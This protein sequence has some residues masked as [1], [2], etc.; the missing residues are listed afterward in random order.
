MSRKKQSADKEKTTRDT[1]FGEVETVE[2]Y[3]PSWYEG[4]GGLEKKGTLRELLTPM[5][6]FEDSA[7]FAEILGS[8]TAL[9]KAPGVEDGPHAPEGGV[10]M[11]SFAFV[12]QEGDC[13]DRANTNIQKV[14]A[15]QEEKRNEDGETASDHNN[16]I[17]PLLGV[18]EKLHH[19]VSQKQFLDL[20]KI[21]ISKG[22]SKQDEKAN[23]KDKPRPGLPHAQ[24]TFDD[25]WAEME[26][27]LKLFH[28]DAKIQ[29]TWRT[30]DS[31]GEAA[32]S[33]LYLV[34]TEGRGA[35]RFIAL[36]DYL[37]WNLEFEK[38]HIIILS[39]PAKE[40]DGKEND[41]EIERNDVGKQKTSRSEE[42]DRDNDDEDEM[43]EKHV[44]S[45]VDPRVRSEASVKCEYVVSEALTCRKENSWIGKDK[46]LLDGRN[47][48]L[49]RY[50]RATAIVLDTKGQAHKAFIKP[51]GHSFSAFA[52]DPGFRAMSDAAG[53]GMWY[54]IPVDPGLISISRPCK[55]WT[56]RRLVS[57]NADSPRFDLRPGPVMHPSSQRLI[58]DCPG[59]FLHGWA[60][61]SFPIAVAVWTETKS[62]QCG[63]VVVAGTDTVPF[64]PRKYDEKNITEIWVKQKHADTTSFV[65]ETVVPFAVCIL[66]TVS[67]RFLFRLAF[68]EQK[69][70]EGVNLLRFRIA[71]ICDLVC[72]LTGFLIW[73]YAH[74]SC[75]SLPCTGFLFSMV[76]SALRGNRRERSVPIWIIRWPIRAN[77]VKLAIISTSALFKVD[78]SEEQTFFRFA[79]IGVGL[80]LGAFASV[81]DTPVSATVADLT[82]GDI[83]AMNYD[84]FYRGCGLASVGLAGIYLWYTLENGLM[85]HESVPLIL[86]LIIEAAFFMNTASLC[87]AAM[88]DE[89]AFTSRE[90]KLA[91][92]QSALGFS[93]GKDWG[94]AR[95]ANSPYFRGSLA[96]F[97]EGKKRECVGIAACRAQ[98]GT[99]YASV[100]TW[101]QSTP[102]EVSLVPMVAMSGPVYRAALSPSNEYSDKPFSRWHIKRGIQYFRYRE[103]FIGEG[104]DDKMNPHSGP[105]LKDCIAVK[106]RRLSK[107]CTPELSK[108]CAGGIVL[109]DDVTVPLFRD[110]DSSHDKFY[111]V[112][113]EQQGQQQDNTSG[114]VSFIQ[115]LCA[116]FR[117]SESS[118]QPNGSEQS[119]DTK[120]DTIAQI[121]AEENA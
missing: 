37:D 70:V 92:N 38:G 102:S 87:T 79:T 69:N 42:E 20:L 19:M 96:L 68:K 83:D 43:D 17:E 66:R 98:S 49:V 78:L 27:A 6:E 110:L 2:G 117:E 99:A 18:K 32:R 88:D 54:L 109:S 34:N 86:S 67:Y 62:E 33:W 23:K 48:E 21:Y 85:A 40:D 52:V 58:A 4:A 91:G 3:G 107:S 8:W 47:W 53:S 57:A 112:K 101:V 103:F 100:S 118:A 10:W 61:R 80:V 59:V 50:R 26:K 120:N 16:S 1:A 111:N 89:I 94:Q 46:V 12:G 95:V 5:F 64:L 119:D 105:R 75:S 97:K 82:G 39:N 30:V 73:Q 104:I 113:D 90:A 56:A 81:N 63:R 51:E 55:S 116:C 14:D 15:A 36:T 76:T 29:C 74:F 77:V 13:Q 44:T 108:G 106:L 60:H 24:S 93:I 115:Y 31:I 72:E 121:E 65:L 71:I 41:G 9:W 7:G 35:N 28:K 22:K 114:R 45:Y 11:A 84:K 25:S